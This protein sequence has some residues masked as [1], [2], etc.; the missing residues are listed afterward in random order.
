MKAD[1]GGGDYNTPQSFFFFFFFFFFFLWEHR[2]N[3]RAQKWYQSDN[4][5]WIFFKAVI[6]MI[7]MP[8]SIFEICKKTCFKSP[9]SPDDGGYDAT[10]NLEFPCN[11]MENPNFNLKLH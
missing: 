8:S 10:N 5:C 3:R 7:N 1:E 4:N 9:C 2:S 6:S 11:S